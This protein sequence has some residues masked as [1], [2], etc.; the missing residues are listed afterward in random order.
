[1][2]ISN[3]GFWVA[4]LAGLASF[5]SP[6]VFALVPAYVGYLSSRSVA[7]A[8]TG[9]ADRLETLS[10]AFAFVLGFTVIFVLL[11]LSASAVGRLLYD[12]RDLLTKIGGIVVILF[13]LHMTGI[14][15][16]PFLSYDV[17]RQQL[18]DTKWGYL[19]S[20]LM[21]VFFSAGW[22]PC[23][24]PVLGA[25]MTLSLVSENVTQGG[26]L[27]LAY[28]AGLAI[29]FLIA[30][31]Q[32]SLVTNVLRKYGKLMHYVEIGLGIFLIGIGVMLFFGRF[33]I[34]ATL[35]TA[36]GGLDEIVVGQYLLIGIGILGLLGLIP[37]YIAYQKGRQ[38][39]DW[40]FFGAFLFPIALPYAIMIKSNPEDNQIGKGQVSESN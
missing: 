11:G 21:G 22:S 4:F 34:F 37:A 15:R 19:S 18:P 14:I 26:L 5:L 29:P 35:G 7:S 30:A 28:S 33:E 13:G 20:F 32:I 1:M 24:G 2:E 38:F 36:I 16:I 31:T 17:R 12:Q 6:C 10:H 3:I 27:L 39:I 40:W 23:V 9:K 25:I 8:K